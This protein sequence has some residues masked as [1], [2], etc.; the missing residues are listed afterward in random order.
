MLKV[1][2]EARRFPG[3]DK[4][5][6]FVL[7]TRAKVAEEHHNLL[8]T[9]INE[10]IRDAEV[11][12]ENIRIEKANSRPGP[13]AAGDSDELRAAVLNKFDK[14]DGTDFRVLGSY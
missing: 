13:E 1:T 12:A 3:W 5:Q 8:F 7:L 4:D 6:A 9:V 14:E 2:E 11:E 10:I